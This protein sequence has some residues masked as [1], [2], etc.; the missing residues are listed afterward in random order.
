MSGDPDTIRQQR[1]TV[2]DVDLNEPLTY[3]KEKTIP[4]TAIENF[5]LIKNRVVIMNPYSTGIP[6]ITISLYEQMCRELL[7]RN[8]VVFTNTINDQKPVKGSA[9]LRCRI[10]E[11]YSIAREIPLVVSVRSG[12]LDYLVPS[13]VNMFVLY[14]NVT[15]VS[16]FDSYHLS[17]WHCG[18]DICEIYIESKADRQHVQSQFCEFLDKL[19]ANGAK[20]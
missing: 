18:G 9:S 12:I 6:Y 4:V 3:H 15:R 19:E 2:F 14:E 7:R 13:G 17:S 8:Y 1:L 5:A 16:C 20:T 10:R 11:L